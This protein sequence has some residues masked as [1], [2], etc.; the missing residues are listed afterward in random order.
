VIRVVRALTV[1]VALMGVAAISLA[2]QDR[3][4]H[5]PESVAGVRPRRLASPPMPDPDSL[6]EVAADRPLFAELTVAAPAPEQ[7]PYRIPFESYALMGVF[8]GSRPSALVADGR[9]DP[10][11]VSVGDSVG[12]AIVRAI[13]PRSV[14]LS[15][16]DS[17][18]TLI[19]DHGRQQ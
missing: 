12:E 4:V 1:V 19:I 6:L 14:R 15:V 18:F 2:F 7:V 8:A 5:V 16:G 9:A 10:R 3:A 11:L 17:T 13:Q